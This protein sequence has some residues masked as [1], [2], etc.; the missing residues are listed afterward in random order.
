MSDVRALLQIDRFDRLLT[1][2]NVT[3]AVTREV[4]HNFFLK[5]AKRRLLSFR[6]YYLHETPLCT[7]KNTLKSALFAG[8]PTAAADLIEP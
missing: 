5:R 1:A 7:V 2:S 8:K 3:G 6:H 4:D